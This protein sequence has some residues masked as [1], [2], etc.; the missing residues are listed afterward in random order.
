MVLT[1]TR[2]CAVQNRDVEHHCFARVRW[3]ALQLTAR[4]ALGANLQVPYLESHAHASADDL[5]KDGVLSVKRSVVRQVDE[6]LRTPAVESRPASHREVAV[7]VL[8]AG[9]DFQ[10]DGLV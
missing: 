7:V 3:G 6:E 8:K 4:L 9:V 2:A 1:A 10:G 5:A